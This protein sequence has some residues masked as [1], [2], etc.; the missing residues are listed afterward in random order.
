ME[1]HHRFR[2]LF[3]Q[4][5]VAN[6]VF[7]HHFRVDCHVSQVLILD[8]KTLAP[9]RW[10]RSLETACHDTWIWYDRMLRGGWVTSRYFLLSFFTG[11]SNVS[12]FRPEL[13]ALIACATS[14]TT[15]AVEAAFAPRSHDALATWGVSVTL[16]SL[17]LL[18]I[19]DGDYLVVGGYGR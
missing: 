10:R 15:I 8:T 1:G 9:I 18:R 19:A 16:G 17:S 2:A 12:L 14:T 5:M 11:A 6:F 3:Q 4:A 7:S 13:I